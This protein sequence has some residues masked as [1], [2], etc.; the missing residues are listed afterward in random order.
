MKAIA[1]EEDEVNWMYV[2]PLVDADLNNL[3]VG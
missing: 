3:S 1:K 2:R